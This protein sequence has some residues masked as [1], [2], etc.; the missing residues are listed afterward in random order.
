MLSTIVDVARIRG[1]GNSLG[2]DWLITSK[3][4][5]DRSY[6]LFELYSSD[7]NFSDIIVF[8]SR[9]RNETLTAPEVEK[10]NRIEQIL[11]DN[12]YPSATILSA[13]DSHFGSL[14]VDKSI[15]PVSRVAIDISAMNF[16]EL[17][18]L[19]YYFLKIVQV[20]SL[21]VFY[22]EPDIYRYD[23]YDLTSYSHKSSSVSYNYPINYH[24]TKTSQSE[25]IFVAL[26]GFQKHVLKLMGDLCQFQGVYS[27]NGFPSYYPKAKDI[28]LV[29]NWD[30]LSDV[31]E[32]HR[33]SAEANNPFVC[34]NSLQEIRELSND[35]FMTVCPLSS[36]PMTLGACLFTIKYP[37][38]T[39]LVYPYNEFVD[40]KASGVGRTFCYH[41]DH[42]YIKP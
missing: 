16:W 28:S 10:Y 29:N 9:K 21:D 38:K 19:I 23:N 40:T 4:S 18:D 39:R 15:T 13:E 5:D 20:N 7:I 35:A 17:S 2:Y 22:T 41:I 42:S 26:L 1:D 30:Y 3:G 6:T 37:N 12:N 14:L 11:E 31:E 34:F 33:F 25:E 36:K 8:D 32:A 27:I 24:S